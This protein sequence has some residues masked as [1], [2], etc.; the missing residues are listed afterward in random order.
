[1]VKKELPD[2]KELLILERLAH[3]REARKPVND[4]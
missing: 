3:P 1:M 4:E 2:Y